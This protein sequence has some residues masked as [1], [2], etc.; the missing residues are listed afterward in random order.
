MTTRT[1]FHDSSLSTYSD[2]GT[3]GRADTVI[4]P[5]VGDLTMLHVK[6]GKRPLLDRQIR[7][8]LGQNAWT[9]VYELQQNDALIALEK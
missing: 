9:F 7:G 2:D 5:I 6:N 3:K 4:P 8:P 1:N